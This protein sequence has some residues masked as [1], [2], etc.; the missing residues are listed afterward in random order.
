VVVGFVIFGCSATTKRWSR[1]RVACSSWYLATR[2]L[3]ASASSTTNA[4]RS[5]A[6]ANRISLSMP[7]VATG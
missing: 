1:P 5:L 2:P 6:D 7:S 3:T 4:A